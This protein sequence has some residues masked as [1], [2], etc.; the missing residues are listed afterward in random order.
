MSTQREL[1][2]RAK[3]I[4]KDRRA[5]II[6]GIRETEL[7]DHLKELFGHM[8]PE[9]LVENTHG[10]RERGKDLVIVREDGISRE[11]IGIVVKCGDISA[12][13]AG[14]VDEVIEHV[15]LVIKAESKRAYT[16][17]I[18]QIR[19][20]KTHPAELK[21]MFEELPITKV[22]VV[23]AGSISNNVRERITRE[24]N[25]IDPPLD[26]DWLV[27]NFTEHYPHIFFEAKT[28]DFLISKIQEL[29][30]KHSISNSYATLS[31]SEH[32]TEPLLGPADLFTERTENL[33]QSVSRIME[34]KRM[35]FS[36]LATQI[37]RGGKLILFG[38]QGTGKSGSLAKYT[39]DE[40]KRCADKLSSTTDLDK[41]LVPVLVHAS[42]VLEQDSAKDLV[43]Q[44][45][46]QEDVLTAV[47]VSVIAVDG[48]DEVSKDKRKTVLD[49]TEAFANELGCA[50]VVAS[51]KVTL[52]EE[53]RKGYRELE[54]LP[55]E[56]GQAIKFLSKILSHNQPALEALT[57]GLGK[58][59]LHFPLIPLSLKMLIKLAEDSKEVPASITELYE[60]YFDL[61]LGREDPDKGI[62]VLF[63]YLVKRRFLA[64]LAYEKFFTEDAVLIG[65]EDFRAF[66]SSY[67]QR[68]ITDWTSEKFSKMLEE[69]ERSGILLIGQEI[70]FRHRTYLEYFVALYM[71]EFREEIQKVNEV[72]AVSHMN[73]E[74]DDVTFFY[75]GIQRRLS[76]S[77][78]SAITNFSGEDNLKISMGKINVGRLL[79]AG[80][81]SPTETKKSGV[82]LA[83]SHLPSL[84]LEFL[85]MLEDTGHNGPV[86]RI[87]GDYVV[88]LI[89]DSAFGS[90][91]LKSELLEV[92]NEIQADGSKNCL[93]QSVA[94]IY[95]LRR[96]IDKEAITGLV[97]QSLTIL[98]NI[99]AKTQGD[100]TTDEAFTAEEEMRILIALGR[101][102]VDRNQLEK[103]LRNKLKRVAR[104]APE[105]AQMVLPYKRNQLKEH[106]ATKEQR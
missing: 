57:E 15:E 38:D 36:T 62:E 10:V 98:E 85:K 105:V 51:R 17:I 94:L 95:V 72:L 88:A 63:D 50:L 12:K 29:E 86:P 49:K 80:W 81:H 40:L 76:D 5:E 9:Y 56:F 59:S 89:A 22:L 53:P 102:N 58:L 3:A 27:E 28:I 13:T 68:F 54:L 75:V 104:R 92:I 97:N 99:K 67:G 42:Q 65:D 91:A 73:I 14:D 11:V 66:L 106:P 90:A 26:I 24:L 32:F 93:I 16:E 30:V 47:G 21:S 69:L 33:A 100:P 43:S 71:V 79:Q 1:V 35:P 87:F 84:R 103:T 61:A 83:A 78:L 8:Q 46:N 34:R 18:S 41:L 44:F 37:K 48:L 52:V 55:F 96:L 25:H 70:L 31:L 77:L 20:A 82:K 2:L 74:W 7:H 4:P 39:I 23:I 19:Q 6:K 101:A 60:R 64:T 45:I